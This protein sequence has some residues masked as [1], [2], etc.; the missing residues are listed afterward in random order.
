MTVTYHPFGIHPD[1]RPCYRVVDI[2]SGIE[3]QQER[4]IYTEGRGQHTAMRL[5]YNQNADWIS[6]ACDRDALP[7][8]MRPHRTS[9]IPTIVPHLRA[10][11]DYGKHQNGER[12]RCNLGFAVTKNKLSASKIGSSHVFFIHMSSYE[13]AYQK[14]VLCYAKEYNID[15]RITEILLASIPDRTVFTEYLYESVPEIARCSVSRL[16]HILD[17]TLG[18]NIE[19]L[20]PQSN[21]GVNTIARGLYARIRC[22]GNFAYPIFVSTYNVR[23]KSDK[24]ETRSFAHQIRTFGYEG[25]YKKSV[26]LYVEKRGWNEKMRAELMSRIPDKSVFFD[27]LIPKMLRER[28]ITES[29][30]EDVRAILEKS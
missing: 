16:H 15:Q 4:I 19:Q 7:E 20:E 24:S 23:G 13:Q 29:Q 11:I 22:R 28:K 30:A 8:F 25:A 27:Y 1:E 10:V 26:D 14:A 17:G 6:E 2:Y 21:A 9:G 3:P 18:D 12:W 5:A